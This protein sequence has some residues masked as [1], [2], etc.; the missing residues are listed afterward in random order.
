MTSTS[1]R[2][3]Q[4]VLTRERS[5]ICERGKMP[6]D[7]IAERRHVLVQVR[8][9]LCRAG[10]VAPVPHQVH[11]DG[12]KAHSLDS[13]CAHAV[14]GI[15]RNALVDGAGGLGVCKHLVAFFDERECKE[16]GAHICYNPPDDHLGP[17]RGLDRRLEVLVVPCVHFAVT[18]DQWCGWVLV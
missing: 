11:W 14:I 16:S 13:G 10:A 15:I 17:P 9:K 12:K 4:L 3:R 7:K 1:I 5:A 8:E 2:E 6:P 18:F